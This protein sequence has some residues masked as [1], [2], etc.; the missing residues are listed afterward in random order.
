MGGAATNLPPHIPVGGAFVNAPTNLAAI[1]TGS[2][3]R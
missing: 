3:S 2:R 1:I